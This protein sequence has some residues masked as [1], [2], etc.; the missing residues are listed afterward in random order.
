ME[1]SVVSKSFLPLAAFQFDKEFGGAEI[2]Q[3]VDD[4]KAD[5][6]AASQVAESFLVLVKVDIET[7]G[8]RP[9]WHSPKQRCKKLPQMYLVPC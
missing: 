4:S 2:G 7:Y 1:V 5:P 8:I 3:S 6:E 9:I